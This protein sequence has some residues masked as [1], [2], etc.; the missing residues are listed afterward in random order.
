MDTIKMSE[1]NP[2]SRADRSPQPYSQPQKG[3]PMFN[4][5]PSRNEPASRLKQ[6]QP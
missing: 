6:K 5:T 3:I 2:M 4:L 1:E